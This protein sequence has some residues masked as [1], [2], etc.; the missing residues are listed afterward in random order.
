MN[1]IIFIYLDEFK[2]E[3]PNKGKYTMFKNIKHN[4]ERPIK[5]LVPYSLLEFREIINNISYCLHLNK[6]ILQY[7][8]SR[9]EL[10]ESQLFN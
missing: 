10:A 3:F 5:A 7:Y 8:N 1:N 2:Q 6:G 4:G 9:E